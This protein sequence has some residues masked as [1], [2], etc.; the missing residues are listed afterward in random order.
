MTDEQLIWFNFQLSN[1]QKGKL[2]DVATA[3]GRSMSSWLRKQI[4]DAYEA[5]LSNAPAKVEAA[6]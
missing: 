1:E 3:D 5:M 4:D 2:V 6:Q